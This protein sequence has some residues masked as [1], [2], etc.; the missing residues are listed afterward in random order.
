MRAPQLFHKRTVQRFDQH[1]RETAKS[2]CQMHQKKTQSHQASSMSLGHTLISYEM[3]H[4]KTMSITRKTVR[5]LRTRDQQTKCSGECSQRSVSLR[6]ANGPEPVQSWAEASRM[7][8]IGCVLPSRPVIF[9]TDDQHRKRSV[10]SCCGFVPKNTLLSASMDTDAGN[11]TPPSHDAAVF[12]SRTTVRRMCISHGESH[13]MQESSKIRFICSGKASST[14]KSVNWSQ[15]RQASTRV[16]R[17]RRASPV[18]MRHTTFS[19]S[20]ASSKCL[21]SPRDCLCSMCLASLQAFVDDLPLGP[22]RHR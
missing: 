11:P 15:S 20:S 13:I 14:T 6:E 17:K 16:S 19:V 4:V 7:Q 2:E 9:F 18:T 8:H 21:A 12:R 22:H 1:T 10:L 3:R 5:T